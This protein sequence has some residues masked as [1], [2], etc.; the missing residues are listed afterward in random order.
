MSHNYAYSYTCRGGESPADVLLRD[1]SVVAL[2][3]TRAF[4]GDKSDLKVLCENHGTYTI[5]DAPGWEVHEANLGSVWGAHYRDE[6]R[7]LKE[8]FAIPT[9]A[10]W[11]DWSA[12]ELPLQVGAF[13][14]FPW[15][16]CIW[17]GYERTSEDGGG[18]ECPACG[19]A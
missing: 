1:F 14:S 3:I 6:G 18:Y 16:E 15:G 8:R 5:P 12:S 2:A 13:I 10:W 4:K 11:G 9:I 19:G 17:C 7:D